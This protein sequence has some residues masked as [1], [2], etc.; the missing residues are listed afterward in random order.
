[1]LILLKMAQ[2]VLGLLIFLFVCFCLVVV[3]GFFVCAFFLWVCGG[4]VF[5]VGLWFGVC[6]VVV[7]V[8]GTFFQY[9]AITFLT[10]F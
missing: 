6:L 5:C 9:G 1:L 10:F 8:V 3:V 7:V 2:P 4:F